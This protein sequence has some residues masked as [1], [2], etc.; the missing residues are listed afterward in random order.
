MNLGIG[1]ALGYIGSRYIPDPSKLIYDYLQIPS[2]II[3]TK[4]NQITGISI[5]AF[6]VKKI[7]TMQNAKN[8]NLYNLNLYG[9]PE[10][11][12]IP[13]PGF[14]YQEYSYGLFV[15]FSIKLISGDDYYSNVWEIYGNNM[16]DRL[17]QIIFTFQENF[18]R[19][20]NYS[21]PLPIYHYQ[22]HW[23]FF[24]DVIPITSIDKYKKQQIIDYVCRKCFKSILIVGPSN[25]GKSKLIG[26]IANKLN[27]PIFKTNNYIN[28]NEFIDSIKIIP[29]NSIIYVKNI[30]DV[31]AKGFMVDKVSKDTVL[32]IFDF[33]SK[34]ILVIFSANNIEPY[35]AIPY[36]FQE[37]RIEYVVDLS[38]KNYNY[39]NIAVTSRSVVALLRSEFR[40]LFQTS[41]SP[42]TSH[43]VI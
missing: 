35:K 20:S 31:F 28:P 34:N 3:N 39:E 11:V 16:Q 22:D 25:N 38:K 8:V 2:Q 29:A 7:K 37:G 30:D 19:I 26:L 33:L 1:I 12:S 36:L 6:L 14:S 5:L 32:G 23:K 17:D 27:R 42:S 10:L 15:T 24:P 9:T 21:I 4:D 40:G 18:F 41:V 13:M 43:Q